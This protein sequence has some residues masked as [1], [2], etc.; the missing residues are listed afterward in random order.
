MNRSKVITKSSTIQTPS[1]AAHV[2]WTNERNIEEDTIGLQEG[3]TAFSDS[4]M[5][6]RLKTESTTQA[7]MAEADAKLLRMLALKGEIPPSA[8][9][10][11]FG[12]ELRVLKSKLKPKKRVKKHKDPARAAI[13]SFIKGSHPPFRNVNLPIRIYG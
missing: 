6:K 13:D 4:R 7:A 9:D 5:I 12:K 8:N 10:V 2:T 3:P 1:N 11:G